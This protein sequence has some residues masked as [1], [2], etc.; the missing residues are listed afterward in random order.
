MAMVAL[1]PLRGH[2]RA[3]L[4]APLPAAASRTISPGF[5]ETMPQELHLGD[6]GVGFALLFNFC[7][8]YVSGHNATTFLC[9]FP[10]GLHP[11][12]GSSPRGNVPTAAPWCLASARCWA[13][14][15]LCV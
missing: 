10:V 12:S 7:L 14:F 8:N 2:V 4:L 1:A 6:R 15:R 5:V 13:V 11:L 3:L 9:P